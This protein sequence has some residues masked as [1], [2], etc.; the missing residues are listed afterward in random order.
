[1]QSEITV[2][3]VMNREYVG[4][5]ESDD[6]LETVE[7]L[8]EEDAESAV[9]LR[10]SEPVGVMTERDV[11]GLL[12]SGTDPAKATVGD[13]MTGEVPA[14]APESTVEVA[15]DQM[16]T[17][18]SGRLV[19]TDGATPVGILTERD[20]IATRTYQTEEMV[21]NAAAGADTR[22]AEGETEDS[23]QDQSICETCG[24][25]TRD[26]ARFNGQLL[27]PDCRAM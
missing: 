26:L 19:V 20:L 6:L 25:L 23:F 24:T 13:A 8:L 4:V 3:E 12:V 16:S 17:M 15:A 5:S 22:Q 2:R 10:G 27:C 11:L 18:A 9:V 1:M 21:A 14:V 7:L